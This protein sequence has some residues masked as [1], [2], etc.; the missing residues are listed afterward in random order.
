MNIVFHN[1]HAIWLKTN[2]SCYYAGTKSISKYDYLFNYIY[3]TNQTVKVLVDK[4]SN[5]HLFRGSLRSLNTPVI[6]F[7]A[8]VFLNRLDPSKFEIVR[9]AG[10]LNDN[11]IIFSFLYGSF[12]YLNANQ[13][14]E[15]LPFLAD[16]KRSHAYK[17]VH[18]T[19]YG[20]SP[21]QGALN[22]Q[23]AGIDLFVGENNLFKNSAF[24]RN[25]YSWYNRDVYTLPFVAQDRFRSVKDF[26]TRLNKALSTGTNTH[27]I[28]EDSFVSFFKSDILQPM[29]T[30]IANNSQM[31]A[32]YL[33]SLIT[34]IQGHTGESPDS[35]ENK[36]RKALSKLV[37]PI[38]SV[39][40]DPFRLGNLV[41]K[42]IF[43][44]DF[45]SLKNERGYYK[46][47]IVESYNNYK[48]F[49]V[50]EEVIGLPG[51][52]FVEGM[53]C[54][55]AYVGLR[56]PMYQDLGLMD[57]VHY[58]GYD[59]TLDDLI[60]KISYYQENQNELERIASNGYN[61]VTENFNEEKVARDFFTNLYEQARSKN[62]KND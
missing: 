47:D 25:F 27:K 8:W 54:G 60:S 58:I 17:V 43:Q 57:G 33:D 46:V 4:S 49:I 13:D 1:P 51:I 23:C 50:P 48:M 40:G 45:N 6:D 44:H 15:P 14:T 11:D 26:P 5:A 9:T 19:H 18:L 37:A 62:L 10:A 16:F 61:F 56:D 38:K 52:G 41:Y 39:L 29:R 32:P 7:Y 20:Y 28:V 42:Y 31:L 30:A 24:F 36:A 3:K 55:S 2:I 21:E 59:G 34:N 22:T 12:T 35:D 53:F